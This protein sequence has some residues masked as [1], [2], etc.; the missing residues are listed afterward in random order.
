[1]TFSEDLLLLSVAV[2]CGCCW[3]LWIDGERERESYARRA[4]IALPRGVEGGAVLYKYIRPLP[5][6]FMEWIDTGQNTA[7]K[8]AML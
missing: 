4:W 7:D 3:S 8:G 1:M 2:W 5:S 6:G